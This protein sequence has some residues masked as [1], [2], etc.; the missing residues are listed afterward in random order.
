MKLAFKKKANQY[1]P[2]VRGPGL[3]ERNSGTRGILGIQI[4]VPL[5]W[6]GL[7]HPAALNIDSILQ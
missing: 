2:K 3:K 5:W 6:S 7:E 4:N 1:T